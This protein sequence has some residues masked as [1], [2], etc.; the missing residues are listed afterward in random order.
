VRSHSQSR[1]ELIKVSS[2]GAGGQSVGSATPQRSDKLILP[3]ES[4]RIP[5]RDARNAAWRAQERR[6][7]AKYAPRSDAERTK[8]VQRARIGVT[9]GRLAHI[10]NSSVIRRQSLATPRVSIP[11]V[12]EFEFADRPRGGRFRTGLLA[13]RC[14]SDGRSGRTA[15]PGSECAHAVRYALYEY[16]LHHFH[17]ALKGRPVRSARRRM[18]HIADGTRMRGGT[19]SALGTG[20]KGL[21]R[22]QRPDRSRAAFRRRKPR[23]APERKW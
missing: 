6:I 8:A 2:R 10:S 14:L 16:A 1:K 9:T 19:P 20:R 15:Q 5:L 3:T 12:R 17:S 18:R 13:A 21:R 11:W 22:N 4:S 7:G 23:A